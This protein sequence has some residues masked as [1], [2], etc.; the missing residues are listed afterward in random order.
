MFDWS[1]LERASIIEGLCSLAPRLTEKNITVYE[2]HKIL[3]NYLKRKYPIKTTMEWDEKV[4]KYSVLVGG[5]YY[6]D[7]DEDGK[8]CVELAFVYHP[9]YDEIKIT[10]R[11][12]KGICSIIADTLH[13]EIIHMRQY[14]RRS[15]KSLPNY[16]S[17]AL[18][19]KHREEQ[20]YLGCSDEID[21]YSFNIACEL[22]S[23]FSGDHKL[24][25]QHLD[26]NLK[27]CRKHTNSW[28]MY[29]KAFG[30][31]HNHEII[32]RVKKKVIRYLP[33]AEVGKPFKS[34]DWICY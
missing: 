11:R 8:K 6:S 12:Y 13:H 30:H 29:L 16:A 2:F 32:K 4:K 33:R 24:V 14:R 22:L 7:Y 23:K 20:E 17:T 3:T 27:S 28:K 26:L 9:V 18:S 31:N 25:I 34:S 1:N 19:G 15:F 10:K 5:A 21:A